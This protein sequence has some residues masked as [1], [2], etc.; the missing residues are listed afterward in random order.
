[1]LTSGEV[2]CEQGAPEDQQCGEP[3]NGDQYNASKNLFASS[4]LQDLPLQVGLTCCSRTLM[5]HDEPYAMSAMTSVRSY[6]L[7]Y[8][9][10]ATG[11]RLLVLR[12]AQQHVTCAHEGLVRPD[13]R[14]AWHLCACDSYVTRYMLRGCTHSDALVWHGSSATAVYSELLLIQQAKLLT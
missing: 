2:C 9:L 6:D 3:S 14:C 4:K 12:S 7:V 11:G 1:M 5:K 10:C 8:W 13:W